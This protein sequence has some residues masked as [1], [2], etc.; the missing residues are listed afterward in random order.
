MEVV[1]WRFEKIIKLELNIS[2]NNPLKGSS[3]IPLPKEVKR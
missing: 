3:Y 2:K 1:G